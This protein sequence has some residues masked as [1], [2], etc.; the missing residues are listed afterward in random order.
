MRSSV[1]IL[2]RELGQG[3]PCFVIAEIGLNHNGDIGIAKKLIQAAALAGCA[4]VKFQKRD[5]ANLAIGSVLDA[6]DERFP[7]FGSTYRAIREHLEFSKEEFQELIHFSTQQRMPFFCTAFDIASL[8]FLKDLGMQ[9]YKLA[10]H[11]LTNVPLLEQVAGLGKPVILSTGMATLQEVDQAVALFQKRNTPLVLL[12]C[13]S[14]YPTPPEQANLRIMDTLRDRYQVPVGYSGHEIGYLASLAAVARGAC[15]VERHVTLDRN[16]V[17]FDH[18]LSLDPGELVNLVRQIRCVESTLGDG[19][20][21]LTEIEK[22]TRRKY[23]VS[24]VSKVNIAKGSVIADGMLTLKNPGT[25]IP[26]YRKDLVVGRKA[27]I[28]IAEDSLI[29]V[30]FLEPA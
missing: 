16:M 10:S 25:G 13:V 8:E 18:K 9:A 20:K 11:S 14:S 22:V 5:V 21:T 15:A 27:A 6:K 19:V 23:H 3:L 12:H 7:A 2:G 29:E 26:A 28:D 17:G 1:N 30:G 4:A 24:F